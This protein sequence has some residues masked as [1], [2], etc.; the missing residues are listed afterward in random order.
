M[1][2]ENLTIIIK[3]NIVVLTICALKKKK[4]ISNL[5]IMIMEQLENVG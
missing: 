5:D 4:I 3:D 1:F 2:D